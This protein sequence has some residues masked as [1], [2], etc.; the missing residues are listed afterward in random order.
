MT[1]ENENVKKDSPV[2]AAPSAKPA[3]AAP[4][5]GGFSGARGAQGGRPGEK[6]DFRKNTRKGGPRE[7]R[8]K[9]EYD[10]K[11]INIRRVTRVAAGGKRFNFSVAMIAGNRK[12]SIGVGL[13]KGADTAMAIDKAFRN[14]RKNLI[15]LKLTPE[16]S[17]P[18]D[19]SAKYSSARVMIMPAR[20]RGVIAG[21]AARHVIELAGVRDVNAKLV[22]PT[23]NQLN[24]ARATLKAL[25]FFSTTIIPEKIK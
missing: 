12:G 17:L 5:A 2:S 8:A 22:S 13:G 15:T 21:S 23:K 1:N 7:P 25:S 3:A 9:P 20:G 16:G 11:I 14:A 24:I 19:I 18:H 6:R 4:G 10:Q